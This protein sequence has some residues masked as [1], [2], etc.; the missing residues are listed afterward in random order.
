MISEKKK[1]TV[2]M[3]QT[4]LVLFRGPVFSR[5]SLGPEALGVSITIDRTYAVFVYIRRWTAGLSD[6]R[7]R[8][9]L[10]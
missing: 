2:D 7:F 9:S 8:L 10:D 5:S 4:A 1:E 3:Q 6:V